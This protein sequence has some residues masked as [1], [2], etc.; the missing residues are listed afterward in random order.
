MGLDA[1]KLA[2]VINTSSGR[3]WSS[4]TYN[5]VPNVIDRVPSSNN[6]QGGF[7]CA[8]IAKDLGIAENAS[9]AYNASIPLGQMAHKIYDSL[10][11]S[12]E[13]SK[14]DFGVIYQ[15]IKNLSYQK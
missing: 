15:H 13:F 5:P 8:L 1:K 6:Y 7:S 12:S 14:L 2:S 9:S 11:Q 4:D 3:C 10:S